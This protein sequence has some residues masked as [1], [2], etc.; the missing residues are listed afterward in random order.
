MKKTSKRRRMKG[1]HVHAGGCATHAQQKVPP[2]NGIVDPDLVAKICSFDTQ[3]RKWAKAENVYH[4][5]E[6]SCNGT[7]DFYSEDLTLLIDTIRPTLEFHLRRGG[8]LRIWRNV[9]HQDTLDLIKQEMLSEVKFR[10]YKIQGGYEP[11]VHSM[12]HR[13]AS[14][15]ASA[16]Q[17]GYRYAQTTL[18][19]LPLHHL[20]NIGL[21]SEVMAELCEVDEWNIGVNPICYRSGVD[22]IGK[23]ADNDQGESTIATVVIEGPR[24]RPRTLVVEPQTKKDK[25]DYSHD[26][27]RIEL[28]L[29]PGDVYL[30]DKA[31][32]ANYVHFLPKT[33]DPEQGDGNA[34]QQRRLA[35]VFRDGDLRKFARDS[36]EPVHNLTPNP[37]R[38]YQFGDIKG[39][40]YGG[41]YRRR[42]LASM[43]AHLG[44]QRSISGST[45]FGCDALIMSGTREDGLE[46]DC[47][48]QFVY[49]VEAAKGANALLDSFRKRRPVRVFRSSK[50][51]SSITGKEKT[52]LYRYDGLYTVVSAKVADSPNDPYLFFLVMTHL[53]VGGENVDDGG[54]LRKSLTVRPTMFENRVPEKPLLLDRVVRFTLSQFEELFREARARCSDEEDIACIHTHLL[55]YVLMA[56]PQGLYRLPLVRGFPMPTLD[57]F[58]PPLLHQHLRLRLFLLQAQLCAPTFYPRLLTP[59]RTNA[60][61][62]LFPPRCPAQIQLLCSHLLNRPLGSL[63]LLMVMLNDTSNHLELL[64]EAA[65][66]HGEVKEVHS[67]D[68]QQESTPKRR[69]VDGTNSEKAPERKTLEPENQKKPTSPT[70][71]CSPIFVTPSLGIVVS[72]TNTQTDEKLPNDNV[73]HAA[74]KRR[75]FIEIHHKTVRAHRVRQLNVLSRRSKRRSAAL[76]RSYLPSLKAGVVLRQSR[77]AIEE[78]QSLAKGGSIVLSPNQ[79]RAES[80]RADSTRNITPEGSDAEAHLEIAR[81]ANVPTIG[82]KSIVEGAT[83]PRQAKR[84][85]AIAI[86]NLSPQ[87]QVRKS[88]TI[89]EK[90]GLGKSRGG[91]S[92]LGGAKVAEVMDLPMIVCGPTRSRRNLE[93]TGSVRGSSNGSVPSK[94][95]EQRRKNPPAKRG[96]KSKSSQ[97]RIVMTRERHASLVDQSTRTAIRR[98]PRKNKVTDNFHPFQSKPTQTEHRH[99]TRRMNRT[100]TAA[101]RR[102]HRERKETK[103]SI[104]ALQ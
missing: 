93:P 89:A 87:I 54:D 38:V 65:R 46:W 92:M 9:L 55:R 102:S 35:I 3:K 101:P 6:E 73:D 41:I 94:R 33:E 21:L 99:V 58:G 19:A 16:P 90:L 97:K 67:V 22:R 61:N 17:P 47:I 76:I 30:M 11:R 80:G 5:E 77:S 56:S 84:K 13:E 8:T 88:T 48:F 36:G 7:L 74:Q 24:N 23:H 53:S 104:P 70:K 96:S 62:L 69:R 57:Q 81:T 39:L 49:A 4:E 75:H 14:D 91:D 98:S 71:N 50:I 40:R 31:M 32:Q 10:R 100:S 37:K 45:A 1:S 85:A 66:I 29:R 83:T 2:A 64:S 95:T 20:P 59:G 51:D 15:D 18:K 79:S 103:S 34:E 28:F 12:Y 27:E 82:E 63:L 26:D 52:Q 25:K 60:I 44:I 42:E 86:R 43:G 68:V 72:S 78:D